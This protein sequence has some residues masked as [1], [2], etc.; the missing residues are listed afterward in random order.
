MHKPDLKK[1]NINFTD[2]LKNI[3]NSETNNGNE[4]FKLAFENAN[5]G[6]CLVDLHGNLIKV[7]SE[8]SNIFGYSIEEL[9]SMNVSDIAHTNFK[10][11]SQQIIEKAVAGNSIKSV[12][13]KKY[14]HKNGS[15]VTCSV[16]T[17]TVFDANNEIKFFIS[18][19]QDITDKRNMELKFLAKKAELSKINAEKDKFLSIIAH[20]LRNPFNSIVGLSQE[21]VDNAA[22]QNFDEV[23]ECASI[24][25]RS[26]K[27]AMNLLVNLM[28]WSSSQTGRI[29]FKPQYFDLLDIVIETKALFTE[30]AKQKSITIINSIPS[31][32]I[33]FAD[34]YMISTVLRNLISNAVKYTRQNGEIIID[35]SV[36]QDNLTVTISDNGIGMSQ[37]NIDKLFHISEV[38]S[39]IGTNNESGTGFGLLLCK[40]FISKHNG[41]IWVESIQEKGSKFH[42]KFPIQNAKAD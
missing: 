32:L 6:M 19:V 9:E 30:I 14:F 8:M 40:E 16:T 17:S 39:T 36:V 22:K 26:S 25:L 33:I 34:Q 1:E 41:K 11:I 29:V 7:N 13:E 18:H 2:S 38:Y 15:I 27:K 24:I 5:I 31:I 10:S 4:L 23:N 42:F 35:A 21:L 37:E 12:F 28:E 3:L 20:D